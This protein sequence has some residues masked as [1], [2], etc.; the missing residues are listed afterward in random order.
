MTIGR[1]KQTPAGKEKFAPLLFKRPHPT[2]TK[3]PIENAYIAVNHT[4][5]IN[6]AAAPP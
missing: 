4:L 5:L 3:D 1:S 2:Q 6:F